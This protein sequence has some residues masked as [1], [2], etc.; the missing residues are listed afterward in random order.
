MRK[1]FIRFC[2]SILDPFAILLRLSLFRFP[3]PFVFLHQLGVFHGMSSSSSCQ[4]GLQSFFFEVTRWSFRHQT[5]D[6]PRRS[7][8]PEGFV[9]TWW[10]WSKKLITF[11]KL[12]ISMGS[13]FGFR[14]ICGASHQ[15]PARPD[16]DNNS[17]FIPASF[18]SFCGLLFRLP[19]L[20]SFNLF[21]FLD[22]LLFQSSMRFPFRSK[23]MRPDCAKEQKTLAVPTAAVVSASVIVASSGSTFATSTTVF[24]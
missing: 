23:Q 16:G 8:S 5:F 13:P 14:P 12:L 15:M 19:S 10:D 21:P 6:V 17:D 2:F 11:R 1:G 24:I 3:N 18:S 9:S 22:P 20:H 4:K 7:N